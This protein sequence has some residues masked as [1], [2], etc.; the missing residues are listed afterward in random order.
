MPTKSVIAAL[1]LSFSQAVSRA[2]KFQVVADLTK[3]VQNPDQ[4]FLLHQD[5]GF[6]S[7]VVRAFARAFG[8]F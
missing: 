2:D 7:P 1:D 3:L 4:L 5:L 8:V 6:P